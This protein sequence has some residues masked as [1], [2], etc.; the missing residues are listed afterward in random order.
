MPQTALEPV[1]LA[2]GR[3]TGFS[4]FATQRT[5]SV[6]VGRIQ[7]NLNPDAYTSN[8][9]KLLNQLPLRNIQLDS[10]ATRPD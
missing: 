1:R 7:F 5:L 6:L 9:I 2:A 10:L 3:R 4:V 8:I